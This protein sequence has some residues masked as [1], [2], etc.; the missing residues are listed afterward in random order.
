MRCDLAS[1]AVTDVPVID[2]VQCRQHKRSRM[3]DLELVP[4]GPS[5][6]E[7]VTGHLLKATFQDNRLSLTG[8]DSICFG[9]RLGEKFTNEGIF[10]G[11]KAH[12]NHI[13][14]FTDRFGIWP[15]FYYQ[16]N[17]SLHLSDSLVRIVEELPQPT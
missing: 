15:V 1:H 17:N 16:S 2:S 12:N 5:E 3:Q 8:L 6:F 7:P 14:A 10:G 4:V 13:E 11:W 9:H